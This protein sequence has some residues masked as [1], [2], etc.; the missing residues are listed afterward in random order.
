MLGTSIIGDYPVYLHRP[1]LDQHA[2]ITGGTGASKTSLGISP[3]MTQLIASEECSVV[4]LKGDLA[5]F[6]SARVEAK[7]ANARFKW[8]TNIPECPSYV[9]NPLQQAHLPLMNYNQKTQTVIEAMGLSYGPVKDER[10]FP[11]RT[12]SC[13]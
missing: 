10:S 11:R 4:D 7:R 5:L 9:F 12:K 8:F 2:H 13:C 6:Q 3:L 1:L